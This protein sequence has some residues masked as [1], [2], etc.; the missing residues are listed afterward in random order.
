MSTPAVSVEFKF[1]LIAEIAALGFVDEFSKL[2]AALLKLLFMPKPLDT[3]VPWPNVD[4][5]ALAD[6]RDEFKPLPRSKF[7]PLV[8]VLTAEFPGPEVKL[9]TALEI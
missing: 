7:V 4:P 9:F 5:R 2:V 1:W 6:L 3:L 8:T